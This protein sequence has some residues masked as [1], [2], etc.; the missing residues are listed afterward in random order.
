MTYRYW[1]LRQNVSSSPNDNIED[2][3]RYLHGKS[4]PAKLNQ[5]LV[6]SNGWTSCR[7]FFSTNIHVFC[8]NY[9]RF[10]IRSSFMRA[11][12]VPMIMAKLS[13]PTSKT[14][15]DLLNSFE[16]IRVSLKVF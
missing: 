12:F 3:K 13:Q 8:W 14:T 10:S 9:A 1:M 15:R 16:N 7:Y 2:N 11:K 4:P 6:H 5:L